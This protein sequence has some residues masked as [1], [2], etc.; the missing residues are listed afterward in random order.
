MT[1]ILK[2]NFNGQKAT[3][4]TVLAPEVAAVP[5]DVSPTPLKKKP[6]LATISKT[7]EDGL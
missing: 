6:V 3:R 7:P 2:R 5:G 1:K 4:V